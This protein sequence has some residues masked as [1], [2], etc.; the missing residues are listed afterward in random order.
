MISRGERK[1]KNFVLSCGSLKSSSSTSPR[2]KSTQSF[3]FISR[4]SDNTFVCVSHFCAKKKNIKQQK[5]FNLCVFITF[6]IL[7]HIQARVDPSHMHGAGSKSG[8]LPRLNASRCGNAQNS[9]FPFQ[10][11]SEILYDMLH[12]AVFFSSL[13]VGCVCFFNETYKRTGKCVEL[14]FIILFFVFPPLIIGSR[15]IAK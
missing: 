7:M 10:L 3:L 15:E 9:F 5:N 4:R 13:L 8:P 12:S 11:N 6:F 1:S 14:V 2:S